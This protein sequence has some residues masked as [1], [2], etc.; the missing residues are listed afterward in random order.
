MFASHARSQDFGEKDFEI[1]RILLK[2]D[3]GESLIWHRF[4]LCAIK[5]RQNAEQGQTEREESQTYE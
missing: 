4:D 5:L 1:L 3:F 2:R